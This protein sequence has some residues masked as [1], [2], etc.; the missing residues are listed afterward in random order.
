MI[1]YKTP[2]EIELMRTSALLVC[3]VHAH[4]VPYIKAGITP[5]QLDK[6]AYEFI[7]DN[8]A[9]P[10]FLQ[11]R[12]YPNTLCISINDVVV[13]GI[14]QN[15]EIKEGD[16]L[17]IDCGVYKNGFH[18]DVAYTYAVGEILPEKKQLLT[19]TKKSLL[20]GV[21]NCKPGNRIGDV[22]ESIQKYCES[23]G[24]G[25]VRQLVGHGLGKSLHEDPEVPNFGKKGK[26]MLLK[27]GLTIAIEPMINLGTKNVVQ[28]NDGWT[29]RTADGKVS[30]HYEHNV[31]I[32]ANGYDLLSDYTEIE[33]SI[34][35]NTNI[36][37][38][39]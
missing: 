19:V 22:A 5:L 32:T 4:L 28:D 10:S 21:G 13:H 15:I 16:I 31:A 39:V 33:K 26:G 3:N 1:F 2:Q 30:A 17:S 6:I 25:V 9:K 11:Y 8:G 38:I 7:N 34:K 14:P 24:Y 18:G 29:I 12:G 20:L 35:K 27:P 37:E 36:L 23:F